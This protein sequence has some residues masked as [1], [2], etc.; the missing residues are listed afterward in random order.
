MYKL[1]FSDLDETLL[2]GNEVP[3]FNQEAILKAKQKGVKF[4]PC[5]G[6]GYDMVGVIMDQLKMTGKG[7]EYLVCYNGALVCDCKE[8]KPLYFKGLDYEVCRKIFDFGLK[9]DV[10]FMV[11]TL[12]GCHF[13]RPSEFEVKR[14]D[15]QHAKHYELELDEF[16]K[17]QN[18]HV[19]KFL[20]Q[21]FDENYLLSIKD[22]IPQD[23]L[24]ECEIT[25][26][27]SRYL[28]FNAKNVSKGE[29]VKFLSNYLSIPIEEVIAIG[30]NYNDTSM[31]I[32]AGMGVAV[33]CAKDDIK[34][35]AD[36]VTEK[37][38]DEGAVKEVI[39][40]FIL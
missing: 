6:R 25:L 13:F 27:S 8:F 22:E 21:N 32:E 33:K 19:C 15:S 36:Y 28:E 7:D 24:D 1:I 4:V 30:D 18:T 17:I 23:I 38:F 26:S 16:Y 29:G 5:T 35:K 40:R 14:K 11:F 10:C 12:E 31:I 34:E 3:L 9:Y 39:E 2:I 37:D 20:F